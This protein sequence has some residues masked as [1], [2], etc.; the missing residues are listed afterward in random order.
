MW[1]TVPGRSRRLARALLAWARGRLAMGCLLPVGDQRADGR[2]HAL[3]RQVLRL[4]WG[5]TGEGVL[6]HHHGV[7]GQSQGLSPDACRLGESVGGDAHLPVLL[8]W[9][10]SRI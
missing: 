8:L 6:D 4:C 3:V 9:K 7:L 5:F 1:L 2:L 10:L